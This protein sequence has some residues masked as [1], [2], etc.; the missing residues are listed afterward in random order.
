MSLLCCRGGRGV[1]LVLSAVLQ[2][3]I[4]LA[5]SF[6][7]LSC[8]CPHLI[9]KV[10]GVQTHTTP[11]GFLPGFQRAN[12]GHLASVASTFPAEP[13]LGGF[14]KGTELSNNS[15]IQFNILIT[16]YILIFACG[17]HRTACK[18]GFSSFTG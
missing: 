15:V 11:P 4:Y 1:S 16:L 9:I 10:P 5:L 3:P 17:G 13:Y 14:N 12:L 8:V 6:W 18:I 2:V 7:W